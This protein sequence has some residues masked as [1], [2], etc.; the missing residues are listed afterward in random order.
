MTPDAQA[1]AGP[2]AT[3]PADHQMLMDIFGG[4]WDPSPAFAKLRESRPVA[5]IPEL[6]IWLV[7]RYEDCVTVI[8]DVK[9]FG[10]MPTDMM[11]EVPDELKDVLPHGYQ[12]WYPTLINTDPPVHTR[13]RKLAQ[14]PITPRAVARKEDDIRAAAHAIVDEFVDDGQADILQA[15]ALP[16][17]IKVLQLILGIPPEDLKKFERWIINTT[18]LFNP[19]I[20]PEQ[21]LELARD[22]VDFGAYVANAIQRRRDEPADDLISELIAV[23]EEGEKRLTDMEVQGVVAQLIL[24]GFD[25][26]AGALCFALM[27]L[28]RNPEI[29]ERVRNDSSLLPVVVE[30]TVRRSTPVRGVV[31]QTKNDVV[32]NGQTIPAGSRVMAMASSANQDPEQFSC[33]HQFDIDRDPSELRRHIGFGQGVHKCI[34]QPIAQTD[35]RVGLEVLL[36]RLPNLRLASEDMPMSPG[37]IFLRP[38]KLELAWDKP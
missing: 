28:C 26:T 6:E 38:S 35:I 9:N 10:H 27:H 17:P 37:M 4:T 20:S 1:Q 34:G 8:R 7:S 15:F 21:R 12:V 24:A 11:S 18:E 19:A 22:Q 5:H 25:T 3:D 31:R 29:L 30:E 16:L 13:I 32:L 33:P 23:E 14:K 36:E 2:P